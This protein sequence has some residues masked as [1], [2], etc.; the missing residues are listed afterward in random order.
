MTRETEQDERTQQDF[1]TYGPDGTAVGEPF[2]AP[3]TPATIPGTG[4]FSTQAQGTLAVRYQGVTVKFGYGAF[5]DDLLAPDQG[6]GL[7]R[8]DI[9]YDLLELLR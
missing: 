9:G 8:L 6:K 7:T 4:V 5:V 3:E 2:R 1:T